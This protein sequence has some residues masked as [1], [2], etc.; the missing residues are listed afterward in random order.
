ML[1]RRLI[2]PTLITLVMIGLWLDYLFFRDSRWSAI[3]FLSKVFV[4]LGKIFVP[5]FNPAVYSWLSVAIVPAVI[6]ACGIILLYVVIT[7]PVAMS[8]ARPTRTNSPIL[9]PRSAPVPLAIPA[10]SAAT[11]GRVSPGN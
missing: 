8:R 9:Q 2:G 7:T 11:D 3:N 1:L 10:E 4:V 5:F 6:I